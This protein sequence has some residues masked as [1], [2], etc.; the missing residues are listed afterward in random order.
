MKFRLLISLTALFVLTGC[1]TPFSPPVFVAGGESF[2]GLV[3]LIQKSDG[4]PVDVVLIHGMC[5]HDEDWADRAIDGI[6]KAVNTN[7]APTSRPGTR[8]AAVPRPEI[9]FVTRQVELAGGTVRFSALIWSPLTAGL[10]QQLSYDNTAEP[11]DCSTAK[12]C[13][14]QR[15][16]VNGMLKDTLLSRP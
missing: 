12:E 1:T 7:L 4:R 10:K 9:R 5:T 11:S 6:V 2:P 8:V 14:P 13:K 16:L 15:A 3:D